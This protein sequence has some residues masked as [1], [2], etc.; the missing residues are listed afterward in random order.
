MRRTPTEPRR[1]GFTLVELLVVIT[2]LAI[3]FALT[4]A[5]VIKAIGKGDE[6]KLRN[7][8]SQ[9]ANGVQAFKTQFQATYVPSH[10]TIRTQYSYAD[11][12]QAADA[13]YLK[14]VWPRIGAPIKDNAGNVIGLQVNWW[15][16]SGANGTT[17]TG[18]QCLVLFLGGPDGVS[19]FSS[20]A[21]DPMAPPPT[22]NPP[23]RVGP[24]YEFDPSRLVG[25]PLTYKD[26]FGLPYVYF[27]SYKSGN[28]YNPTADKVTLT[29]SDGTTVTMVPYQIN[30]TR[31]ANPNAFQI[32]SAGKDGMYDT[33]NSTG[34]RLNWAGATGGSPSQESYDNMANFHPTLLGV[35]AQ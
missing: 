25:A 17:L 3:L 28:D 20:S 9:L 6:V 4:A 5:A 34:G 14:S 16:L 13:Q 2:I 19:G 10:F 35:P 33:A 31:F 1:G 22:T 27:S 12:I 24:F 7:E 18:N 30:A 15:G 26:I 23:P 8:I 11:P 32:I 21:T 29:N